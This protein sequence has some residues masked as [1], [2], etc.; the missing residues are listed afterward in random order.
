MPKKPSAVVVNKGYPMLP[1]RRWSK[2]ALVNAGRSG[3]D[4]IRFELSILNEPSQ[5]G[6][7]ILHEVPAVLAPSSPLS[8]LLEEGFG[9]RLLENQPFD[10]TTLLGRLVETRF[11]KPVD[12]QTQSIVAVRPYP[13]PDSKTRESK[14]AITE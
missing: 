5:S 3:R 7:M 11:S 4:M 9:V 6:R 8:R 14:S 10:L 13:Q 1:T 2:C 12:G